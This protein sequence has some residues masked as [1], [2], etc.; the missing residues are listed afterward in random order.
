MVASRNPACLAR[1]IKSRYVQPGAFNCVWVCAEVRLKCV[2]GCVLDAF[3]AD[4]PGHSVI[5]ETQVEAFA[6][7]G[8]FTSTTR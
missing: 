4:F 8:A 3:G 5:S 7:L 6:R 1:T 2:W